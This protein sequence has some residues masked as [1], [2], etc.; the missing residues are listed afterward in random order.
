M[1]CKEKSRHAD[2]PQIVRDIEFDH[3]LAKEARLL[4]FEIGRTCAISSPD[5][6][7]RLAA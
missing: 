6:L 5:R 3:Q 2:Q 1:G 7:P 4:D